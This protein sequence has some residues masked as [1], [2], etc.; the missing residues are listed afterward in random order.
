MYCATAETSTSSSEFHK[1]VVTFHTGEC[2]S[3][4]AY[5]VAQCSNASHRLTQLA[6]NQSPS[7]TCTS[8]TME[9]SAVLPPSL[10]IVRIIIQGE[11][12]SV[13]PTHQLKKYTRRGGKADKNSWKQMSSFT[14]HRFHR[15][16]V[17]I[18]CMYAAAGLYI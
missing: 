9:S 15:C 18:T 12:Q 7:K 16:S 10:R 2:L 3:T 1:S 4:R 13:Y 17:P 14:L 6:S 8:G 11:F 5:W